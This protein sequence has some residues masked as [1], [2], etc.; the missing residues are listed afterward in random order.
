MLET[1]HFLR[2]D[3][4]ERMR[5]ISDPSIR[6]LLQPIAP[7]IQAYQT[8]AQLLSADEVYDNNDGDSQRRALGGLTLP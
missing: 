5:S 1:D 8:P 7:A 4:L 3:V 6:E 2:R